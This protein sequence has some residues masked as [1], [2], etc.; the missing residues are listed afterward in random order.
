MTDGSSVENELA[1]G[2]LVFVEAE[3]YPRPVSF[4]AVIVKIGPTELWL[5]LAS[6]AR[7]PETMRADQTVRL[8]VARRGAVLLGQSRFLR[9]LGFGTP[10]VFSVVRPGMLE[11][12]QLRAHVRH[13]IELPIRFRHVD[14]ATWE[15]RGKAA[16]GT[17]VNVSPGG[18]LFETEVPL[19]VGDQLDLALSLSGE[20]SVRMLGGV[21]RV[22]GAEE[23]AAGPND[24]SDRTEV[25]LKF[26]RIT[27]V[28]QDRLMRF[29]LVT[30]HRHREAALREQARPVAEQAAATLPAVPPDDA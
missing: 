1:I 14:P 17:T 10:R 23:G 30:E 7:R 5:G 8:T 19:H 22:Q 28:D 13:Q 27:A 25:A 24:G 18:L 26:T 11:R 12:I 21:T 16:G 20:D 2:D 4:Q 15:P 6:P 9:P 29:I 3:T